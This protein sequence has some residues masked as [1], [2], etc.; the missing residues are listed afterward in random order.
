MF[1][2]VSLKWISQSLTAWA[3]NL[4]VF[5]QSFV[6]AVVS[7][8]TAASL[9]VVVVVVV[10]TVTVAVSAA[11]EGAG[12]GGTAAPWRGSSGT[13]GSGASAA[14]AAV[15]QLEAAA[16]LKTI[17]DVCSSYRGPYPSTP[18]RKLLKKGSSKGFPEGGPSWYWLWCPW[19]GPSICLAENFMVS[20]KNICRCTC[21][22]GGPGAGWCGCRPPGLGRG[23][24]RSQRRAAR[25]S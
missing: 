21:G 18:F 10:V 3:S 2:S 25:R 23:R 4:F 16:V 19:P 20:T 24:P 9:V 12:R 5:E 15:G 6:S 1:A 11:A 22:A 8:A 7:V 14:A 13:A 17:K